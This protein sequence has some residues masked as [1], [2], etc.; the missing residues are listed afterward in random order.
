MGEIYLI[1]RKRSLHLMNLKERSPLIPVRSDTCLLLPL[2]ACLLK[3]LC[4]PGVPTCILSFEF[5]ASLTNLIAQLLNWKK[6]LEN[7]C[8]FIGMDM[9]N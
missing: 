6:K 2:N 7:Q 9:D 3:Q 8:I 4:A 1:V 5:E